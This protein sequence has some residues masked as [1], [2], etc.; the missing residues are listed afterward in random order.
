MTRKIHTDTDK[1]ASSKALVAAPRQMLSVERARAILEQSKAVDEVRE[2]ADQAKAIE[3]YLRSRNASMESQSDAAEIR[4][5]AERRLGELTRDMPKSRGAAGSGA[6]QHR[7]AV[8]KSDRTKNPPTLASQGIDKRD[9]HKWQ[10][11]ASIPAKKFDALI[12]ETRAKGERLTAAAP[13]KLVRH[14]AKAELAAELRRKPIPLPAGKFHVIA[15][16]P[17]WAYSKRAG[18][19]TQRGALPYPP[20]TVEEICALGPAVRDRAERDCVLWLWCTNAHMLRAAPAVL[21]AWGWQEKTILTWDKGSIGTG[22][23]LRGQTEHCI[24]AVRGNPIVQLTNQSTLLR[25]DRRE[26]SRKP[27]SFYELVEKLCPGTKLEM[28][29]REPREGWARWGAESELFAG[30]A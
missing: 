12:S 20:M 25:G 30:A 23:W 3:L 28:F 16:D 27:E 1:R 8:A 29:A 9:A 14:D 5:R 11:L 6:N 19:V 26:H 24:M 22:D 13:L 10:Q 4:L 21:D 17:A 7:G 2:V 15:S 18:D